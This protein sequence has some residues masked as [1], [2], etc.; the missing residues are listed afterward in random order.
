MQKTHGGGVNAILTGHGVDERF[1]RSDVTGRTYFLTDALNSSIALTDATGAVKFEWHLWQSALE[2]GYRRE[3]RIMARKSA[4]VAVLLVVI[5]IIL[6][7]LLLRHFGERK[8]LQFSG[9]DRRVEDVLDLSRRIVLYTDRL[10]K[11]PS[12]LSELSDDGSK[13]PVDPVTSKT[14][15]YEILGMTPFGCVLIFLRHHMK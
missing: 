7:V 3:E 8:P 11:L 6:I 10:G 13:I 12:S 1:A 9:D 4:S 14:Y 2:S 5:S 15:F